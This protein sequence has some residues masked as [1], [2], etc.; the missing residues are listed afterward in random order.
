MCGAVGAQGWSR[1]G[2]TPS[3][4]PSEATHSPRHT[5]HKLH[6][7]ET[8]QPAEGFHS[9]RR[10]DSPACSEWTQTAL[11]MLFD[12]FQENI[13]KLKEESERMQKP[14]AAVLRMPQADARPVHNYSIH[15]FNSSEQAKELLRKQMAE[16][17]RTW[18][19]NQKATLVAF[20]TLHIIFMSHNV[21]VSLNQ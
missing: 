3:A 15:T 8:Q 6:P 12:V 20:F 19:T 4:R 16:V 5:Q 13:K 21:I 10:G 2:Y 14:E 7:E 9:G 1:R 17:Y 11:L 18:K